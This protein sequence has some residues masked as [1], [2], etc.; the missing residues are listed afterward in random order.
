MKK[1]YHLIFEGRVQGVGFRYRS[2]IIAN[3]YRLT[4]FV[5]NLYN[6]DVEMCVQGEDSD[7]DKFLEEL[8]NQRFI[9]IDNIKKEKKDLVE[10]GSF[11]IKY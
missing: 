1:R 5:R 4:G 2:Q 6:G 9:S 11:D 7:I 8:Y 10:E 3:K